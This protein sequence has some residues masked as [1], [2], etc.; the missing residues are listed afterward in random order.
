M[1]NSINC[2]SSYCSLLKFGEKF[3]MMHIKLCC[4]P[5][6][7]KLYQK[8]QHKDTNF[9]DFHQ[10]SSLYPGLTNAIC[11]HLQSCKLHF[12]NLLCGFYFT[13][14][15]KKIISNNLIWGWNKNFIFRFFFVRTKFKSEIE[16]FFYQSKCN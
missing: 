1:P 10:H 5:F 2:H 3:N 14:F 16:Y 6:E 11:C 15:L 4:S 7:I 12:V 8:I 13:S 9:R